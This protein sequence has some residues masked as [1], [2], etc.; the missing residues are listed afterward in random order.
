M[1]SI[2]KTILA[3][4]CMG[5][6]MLFGPGA[7]LADANC[8]AAEEI[9]FGDQFA[10][11]AAE[12]LPLAEACRTADPANGLWLKGLTLEKLDK[13]ED[14]IVAFDEMLVLEPKFSGGWSQRGG[15]KYHLKRFD[16][17]LIDYN[18][19]IALEKKAD[20]YVARGN[21]FDDTGKKDLA[22]ADYNTAISLEPNNAYIY[23]ER[24]VAYNVQK[25]YQAALADAQRAVE[26]D[27]ANVRGYILRADNYWALDRRQEAYN[28]Y[29]RYASYDQ[30][31]AYVWNRLGA[32]LYDTKD[33][34]NSILYY[35]KALDLAPTN[36]AYL[37][38]R[39]NSKDDSKDTAGA[40]ADYNKAL[41][42]DPNYARGYFDRG[43]SLERQGKKA[44]AI[45]D[46]TKAVTLDPAD[47]SAKKRLDILT[48]AAPKAQ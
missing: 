38:D 2:K 7:A 23:R 20:Y 28:D 37:V 35:N 47:T 42:L 1:A 5:G 33:Y 27:P 15:V 10:A 22:M 8:D 34:P 29:L 30:S 39:A 12:A 31:R 26:L 46:Y 25:N 17:A 13:L 43:L 45:A 44:E 9:V 3:A 11:R 18:Q 14:A 32:Y 36:V 41:S 19:A 24:S 21:V 6:F 48:G 40:M 16:A 4:A